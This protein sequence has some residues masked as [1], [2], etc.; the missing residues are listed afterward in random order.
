LK[1]LNPTP[2]GIRDPLFDQDVAFYPF[3]SSLYGWL[4]GVLV[5]LGSRR[6]RRVFLH[7]GRGIQVSRG[8]VSMSRRARG[9]LLVLA[10]LLLLLKAA[11]YRLAMFDLLFSERG[12][13]FGAGW[14]AARSERPRTSVRL[15]PRPLVQC[16]QGQPAPLALRPRLSVAHRVRDE[17]AIAGVIPESSSPSTKLGQLH[18]QL[19]GTFT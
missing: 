3:W 11:G 2:F 5:C 1:A 16:Q 12:V 10:A 18:S 9:H 8:G 15:S 19:F 13:A 7:P 14:L 6:H 17:G 4:M